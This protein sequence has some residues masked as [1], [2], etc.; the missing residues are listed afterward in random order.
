[1]RIAAMID[2]SIYRKSVIDHAA[3]LASATST[4]TVELLFVVARNEHIAN[5]MPAHPAGAV[6]LSDG[7]TIDEELAKIRSI[8]EGLL[9]EGEAVLRSAGIADVRTRI[10]EGNVDQVAVK[11]SEDVEL[12][13]IGK[14]G[15]HAD[16]A[17]LPLGAN[18]E[19]IARKSKVPVLVVSR[20]FRPVHRGL[21]AFDEDE[22]CS[23]AITSL[24]EASLMPPIPLV[25]L[26]VGEESGNMQAALAGTANK[27]EQAGFDVKVEL[28]PGI[29]NRVIPERVV[30]DATDLVIMGTSRGSLLKSLLFGS[31]ASLV[32]RSTQTPVLLFNRR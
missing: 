24:A 11:T 15:E 20:S 31:L 19:A 32:V 28:V 1:M 14:R 7:M 27:L 8:G 16:L 9:E 4:A 13:V 6:I 12:L 30:T 3:W 18:V 21:L 26:H 5:R 29:A 10:E 17:H 2:R 22:A 23:A 25:L